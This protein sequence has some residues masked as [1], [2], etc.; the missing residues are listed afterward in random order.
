MCVCVSIGGRVILT[1]AKQFVRV[2]L[3]AQLLA[4]VF[5]LD[6]GDFGTKLSANRLQLFFKFMMSGEG[7]CL[8]F[9]ETVGEISAGYANKLGISKV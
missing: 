1:F 7:F 3:C 9:G 5:D 6:A 4:T 2:C 8:K